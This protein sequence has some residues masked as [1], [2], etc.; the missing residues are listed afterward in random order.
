[1]CMVILIITNIVLIITCCV[2]G[3]MFIKHSDSDAKILTT[4]EYVFTVEDKE[5]AVRLTDEQYEGVKECVGNYAFATGSK[6]LKISRPK[7]K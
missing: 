5:I 6:L 7:V 2:L 3:V 1:M 4:K